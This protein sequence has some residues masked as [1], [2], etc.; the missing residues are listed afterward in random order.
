[1]RR[2]NEKIDIWSKG[3]VVSYLN[4][5][6]E[7]G[8]IK[9]CIKMRLKHGHAGAYYPRCREDW[10]SRVNATNVPTDITAYSGPSSYSWPKC[11]DDCPHYVES[12]EF[13]KTA[14]ISLYASAGDET[15]DNNH[16]EEQT[17]LESLAPEPSSKITISWLVKHV[18][19]SLWL[20]ALGILGG[21]F[22]LGIEA[23]NLQLVQDIF[24]LK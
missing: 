10:A 13:T 12:L 17:E 14:S 8:Q 1:M 19:I 3:E 11:P 6:V 24:N 22:I 18:P 20:T 4:K 5:L 7:E 15:I 16:L 2:D 9:P 23:S 21:V